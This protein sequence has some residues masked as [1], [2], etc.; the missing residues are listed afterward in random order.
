MLV[1]DT[2]AGLMESIRADPNNDD[3]RLVYADRLEEM[4]EVERSEFIR[5]QVQLEPLRG[6]VCTC[7][8]YGPTDLLCQWDLFEKL[9]DR[10]RE[11]LQQHWCQWNPYD[12][13]P[14]NWDDCGIFCLNLVGTKWPYGHC[15]VGFHRGFAEHVG[16]KGEK[17][18][19]YGDTLC[20][21]NPI[22]V[23]ELTTLPHLVRGNQLVRNVNKS[24]QLEVAGKVVEIPAGQ[25]WY[26][27]ALKLRWPSVQEWKLPIVELD[28]DG[29]ERRVA[30]GQQRHRTYQATLAAEPLGIIDIDDAFS[31]AQAASRSEGINRCPNCRRENDT[32]HALCPSCRREQRSSQRT[33]R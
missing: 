10:E 25:K 32:R 9:C 21:R 15:A 26:R 2:L 1:D 12:D 20:E 17:W 29:N 7:P 22:R 13:L 5:T 33:R 16:L 27:T 4:G 18:L 19:T 28:T 24:M 3:L 30:D 6:T 31:L 8:S 11:L 23:V 14:D